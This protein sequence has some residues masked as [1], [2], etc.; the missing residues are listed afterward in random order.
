M[1]ICSLAVFVVSTQ[2]WAKRVSSFHEWHLLLFRRTVLFIGKKKKTKFSQ[3]GFFPSFDFKLLFLTIVP[4]YC[5][6]CTAVQFG[7]GAHLKQ[8]MF[9]TA[10]MNEELDVAAGKRG[11]QYKH[12][13]TD[14]DTR[15][16][17]IIQMLCN[18]VGSLWIHLYF[19]PHFLCTVDFYNNFVCSVFVVVILFIMMFFVV[20]PQLH[21]N[22]M[23]YSSF[24]KILCIFLA[25]FSLFKLIC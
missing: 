17:I 1:T 19:S 14:T 7:L 9:R 22:D 20:H 12:R 24:G 5:Y 18:S 8:V 13:H 25:K 10:G 16:I 6:E 2:Q 11:V 4:C 3:L 21:S 23:I 15:R